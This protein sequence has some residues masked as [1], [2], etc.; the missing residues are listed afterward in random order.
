[1]QQNDSLAD[2]CCCRGWSPA[3][4]GRA[5]R[6]AA[7]PPAAGPPAAAEPQCKAVK[8]GEKT[9]KGSLSY[10]QNPEPDQRSFPLRLAA[11]AA[12]AAPAAEARARHEYRPPV[13]ARPLGTGGSRLVGPEKPLEGGLKMWNSH[14]QTWTFLRHEM[15]IFTSDCGQM[16]ALPPT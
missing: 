11:T 10:L 4:A 15:A 5:Y 16:H 12:T 3:G 9:A 1:M 6:R 2:G 14:Q 7:A 8:A 13:A